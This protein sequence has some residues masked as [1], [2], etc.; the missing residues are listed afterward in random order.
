[1]QKFI[2]RNFLKA[3]AQNI[4]DWAKFPLGKPV[5]TRSRGR[6]DNLD[7]DQIQQNLT[8]SIKKPKNNGIRIDPGDSAVSMETIMDVK[9]QQFRGQ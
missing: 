2:F 3:H 8:N 9:A 5:S 7:L 4:G 6:V 1:M